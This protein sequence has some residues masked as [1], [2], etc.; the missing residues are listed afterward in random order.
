[1]RWSE[2]IGGNFFSSPVVLGETLVN[3]S[4]SGDVTI[5]SASERFHRLGTISTGAVVR[6]T[7][8]VAGDTLLM[9][10]DDALWLIR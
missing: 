1:V 2:R 4:D 3:V 5:L 7:M 8:A 10:T 6:S 9:R